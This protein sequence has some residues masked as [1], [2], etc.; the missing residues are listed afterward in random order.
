[1]KFIR[2]SFGWLD[3]GSDMGNKNIQCFFLE[4]TK[5]L[6]A[7]NGV[8]GI[9]VPSLVLSNSDTVHV[10]TREILLKFFDFISIVELGSGTF[11]KTGTNTVVLFLRRKAQRPEPSEHYW[12]RTLD[13]FDNWNDEL[14]TGG[15]AY[16]DIDIVRNYC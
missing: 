15:G 11:G 8:A 14:K 13:F 4:R 12:I 16:A 2:A 7:A 6:L 5:Q 9:V 10:Q 1:M 3:G